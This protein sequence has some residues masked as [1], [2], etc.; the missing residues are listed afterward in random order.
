MTKPNRL[1]QNWAW[2]SEMVPVKV[3][4]KD[5]AWVDG[6]SKLTNDALIPSLLCGGLSVV[7]DKNE[8]NVFGGEEYISSPY[9]ICVLKYIKI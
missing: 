2:V 5:K 7:I 3:N 9:E 6:A 8:K 1:E 4:A